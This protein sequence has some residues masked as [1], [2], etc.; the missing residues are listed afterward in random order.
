MQQSTLVNLEKGLLLVALHSKKK[1]K[2]I[3]QSFFLVK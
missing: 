2:K 3:D 1:K